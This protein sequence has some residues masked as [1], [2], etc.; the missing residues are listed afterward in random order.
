MERILLVDN[1][2]ALKAA[3]ATALR[4]DGYE[5]V[6]ADGGDEAVELAGHTP[7]ALVVT[8]LRLR[9]STGSGAGRGMDGLDLFRRLRERQPR[10]AGVIATAYGSLPSAVEAMR[11]GAS[12]Y[13]TKPF[14]VADLRRVVA[15]VLAQRPAAAELAEPFRLA[16]VPH[17]FLAAPGESRW[18]IDLWTVGPG[19]RGV[20]FAAEPAAGRSVLRALFRCEGDRWARPQ[21]VVA[22]VERRLGERLSAFYGVVDV[23]GRVLRFAGRGDVAAQLYGASPSGADVLTGRHDDVGM[24]IEGNDRLVVASGDAE[25]VDPHGTLA[26]APGLRV[27]ASLRVD[28]GAMVRGLEEER[29]TLRPPC[30]PADYIER[31]EEMAS[32]MGFDEADAFRVT[33]AVAEAVQNAERH[34][35]ER[36]DDGLIEVRYLQTARD[37][38]VEVSDGGRGFDPEAAEPALVGGTDLF[39]ESGRGFLMM[40]ELMDAVEIDSAAGRGTT[41]RMEKGVPAHGRA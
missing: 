35:F 23:A 39:R 5:V 28:L 16:Q 14:R 13:V 10:I 34:A 2:R 21:T 33:T 1:E 11:L 27:G 36:G 9:P 18:A 26:D 8:E 22:S 17:E 19:R 4:Q 37:L 20:L 29:L 15:R 7:F 12:D 6:L 38:V 41:V 25:G 32:R 24:A 40:R 31:S 30:P 3:L